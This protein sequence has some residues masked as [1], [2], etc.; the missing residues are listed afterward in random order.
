MQQG[1]GL[2]SELKATT[3]R[4]REFRAQRALRWNSARPRSPREGRYKLA[5]RRTVS[6]ARSQTGVLRPVGGG[7]RDWSRDGALE[8][9]GGLAPAGIQRLARWSS[10]GSSGAAAVPTNMGGDP[11]TE[12]AADRQRPEDGNMIYPPG[13]ASLLCPLSGPGKA[14][15]DGRSDR[16]RRRRFR[17]AQISHDLLRTVVPGARRN[18]PG[19][20]GNLGARRDGDRLHSAKTGL[21]EPDGCGEGVA[22]TCA[23]HGV[24]GRAAFAHVV[25][26]GLGRATITESAIGFPRRLTQT[27][28][29]ANPLPSGIA[30]R[31]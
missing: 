7:E 19:Q 12:I 1:K 18:N 31:F 11:L 15:I 10:V 22:Q 3:C 17:A 26:R 25:G 8:A 27:A 29:V 24:G 9:R 14:P 5:G 20:L 13:R 30:V 6:W 2:P 28:K 16:D 4:Q 23:A 21:A